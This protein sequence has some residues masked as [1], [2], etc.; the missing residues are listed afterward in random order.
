MAGSPYCES[1][2]A[3]QS[4]S[5]LVA[6]HIGVQHSQT[7]LAIFPRASGALMWTC[8]AALRRLAIRLWYCANSRSVQLDVTTV[9]SEVDPVV[10]PLIELLARPGR[11]RLR[12]EVV[13]RQ[14]VHRA[15]GVPAVVEAHVA[16][17]G[18]GRGRFV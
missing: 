1:T 18:V 5:I 15:H 11:I 6:R 12:A 10:D 7:P 3:S 8:T 13:Q 16:V 17:F 2:G 4:P 14:Q 9:D